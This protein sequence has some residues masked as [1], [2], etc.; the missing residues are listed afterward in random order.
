MS[1]DHDKNQD[2]L[3][4]FRMAFENCHI[5]FLQAIKRIA[6]PAH[7]DWPGSSFKKPDAFEYWIAGVDFDDQQRAVVSGLKDVHDAFLAGMSKALLDVQKNGQPLSPQDFSALLALYGELT[8]RYRRVERELFYDN[9][10]L[11]AFTGLR[12][13]KRLEQDFSTEMDRLARHG[14][15]FCL[16]VMRINDFQAVQDKYESHLVDQYI[17]EVAESA[18][19]S[20]RSFDEVYRSQEHI[21]VFLLK[22][23]D[24]DGGLKAVKRLE[25]KLTISDVAKK[26]NVT[27][28]YYIAE[29]SVGDSFGDLF[30]RLME[31]LGQVDEKKESKV[32]QYYEISPLERLAQEMSE[33][34]NDAD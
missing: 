21:F 9:V 33:E 24:M 10:G 31:D 20:L 23:T 15:P 2:V 1:T 26:M 17:L 14:K 19:A 5:W 4:E 30:D 27:L 29:P 13:M 3:N 6:Y 22:Q 18:K 12:S 8:M 32:F 25:D 28:S 11:D 34:H 7:K 16:A